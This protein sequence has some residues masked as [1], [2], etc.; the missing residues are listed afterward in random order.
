MKYDKVIIKQIPDDYASMTG[1]HK[2]NRSKMPKTIEFL[3]VGIGL[4]GRF[5]TGLDEDSMEINNI[6]DPDE[7]E[8]RRQ[9]TLDLRLFLEQKLQKKL[10]AASPFWKDFGVHLSADNDLI[11]NKSNAL[12]VVMYNAMVANRYVAP[13]KDAASLPQYRNAKYYAYVAERAND[14]AV[15]D[16]LTRAKLSAKLVD[17]YENPDLMLLIGQYLE[18]D[19]YKAGMTPKTLF[20]MLSTFVED[21]KEPDNA[22]R[23]MKAVDVDVNDLQFKITVDRAIKRKIIRYRDGYYQRGQVT[24]G[25]TPTDVV[26]NLRKP[27]FASEFLSIKEEIE[28]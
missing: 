13:D 9:E 5:I 16:R 10:D 12:H 23:F 11:L 2:H 27:E 26:S 8:R 6:S 19:K 22:K 17:M 3:Q 21:T 1:L 25:K 24:L 7:K 4:D 20:N 14:E 28:D 15:V 18:G